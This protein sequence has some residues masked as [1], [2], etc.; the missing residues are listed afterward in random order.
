MATRFL[1]WQ[2]FGKSASNGNTTHRDNSKH[3]H[4]CSLITKSIAKA[5]GH[6]GIENSRLNR[7]YKCK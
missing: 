3:F 5:H 7:F 4:T 6:R 1:F 2:H